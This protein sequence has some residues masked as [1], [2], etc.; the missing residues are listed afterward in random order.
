MLCVAGR[1]ALSPRCQECCGIPTSGYLSGNKLPATTRHSL[2]HPTSFS[3]AGL[4][5]FSTAA[6]FSAPKK[7]KNEKGKT[8]LKGK[9][10]KYFLIGDLWVKQRHKHT[11]IMTALFSASLL[12]HILCPSFH[13]ICFKS[14]WKKSVKVLLAKVR[15]HSILAWGVWMQIDRL[16]HPKIWLEVDEEFEFRLKRQASCFGEE[17]Q[18]YFLIHCPL[19]KG[20]HG[21]KFLQFRIKVSLLPSHNTSGLNCIVWMSRDSVNSRGN[22]IFLNQIQT[23]SIWDS[24]PETDWTF[25]TVMT[26]CE[27]TQPVGLREFKATYST[28]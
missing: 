1:S 22:L 21:M 16:T 25:W 26:V 24:K 17:Q 23:T 6:P 13:L 15:M 10:A 14:Q 20:D 12:K 5:C 2:L 7:T 4:V 28:F 19:Y 11:G 18:E 9:H 3:S 8:C 27:G